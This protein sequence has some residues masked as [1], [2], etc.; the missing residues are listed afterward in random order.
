MA[1]PLPWRRVLDT[2]RRSLRYAVSPT[3]D[4]IVWPSSDTVALVKLDRDG[5]PRPT[6]EDL[7]WVRG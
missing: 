3:R 7:R 1:D 6:E 4:R 2:G 5:I